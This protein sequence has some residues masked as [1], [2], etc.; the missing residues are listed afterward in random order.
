VVVFNESIHDTGYWDGRITFSD[1]DS[2]SG[3][4]AHAV[5]CDEELRRR[6]PYYRPTAGERIV[7]EPLPLASWSM[8]ELEVTPSMAVRTAGTRSLGA[9]VMRPLTPRV[10]VEFSVVNLAS[11]YS[12]HGAQRGFA[13]TVYMASGLTEGSATSMFVLNG[14]RYDDDSP[15]GTTHASFLTMGRTPPPE[16][17]SM[18]LNV[19]LTT[20]ELYTDSSPQSFDVTEAVTA[21]ERGSEIPI[22]LGLTL[23]F[24][25]KGIT[26]DEWDEYEYTLQ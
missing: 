6:F 22:R 17:Y 24:V 4:A 16:S 10:D 5:P 13:S 9:I 15:N 26:V 14:R 3:F 21:P 25:E 1:V 19:M 23:P 8:D 11:A 20:G 7:N 12:I 2:Y 18:E